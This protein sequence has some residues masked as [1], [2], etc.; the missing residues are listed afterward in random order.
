MAER[1][2]LGLSLCVGLLAQERHEAG[3]RLPRFVRN[4]PALVQALIERTWPGADYRA[5]RAQFEVLSQVLV[6]NG[7]APHREPD[8]LAVDEVFVAQ[9]IGFSAL[10]RLRRLAACIVAGEGPP[11]PTP[12]EPHEDPRV[13]EWYAR[14][15][16][17]PANRPPFQHLMLHGDAEGYYVPQ[18]FA[19][20]IDPGPAQF[21]AVGGG[22]GSC[23]Q[24]LDECRALAHALALPPTLELSLEDVGALEDAPSPG[25]EAWRRH[26]VESHACLALMRACEHALRSG[27]ALVFC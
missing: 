12:G 24:L 15:R 23:V 9:M 14:F 11:A 17:D 19:H 1:D 20:V 25:P 26:V 27:A 6:A 8:T 21:A 5:C 16:A 10:H 7:A 22:I 3:E 18:D 2:R 13:A 4:R